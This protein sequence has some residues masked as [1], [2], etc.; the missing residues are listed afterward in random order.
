MIDFNPERRLV[1]TK[2]IIEFIY[3]S[4]SSGLVE[5]RSRRG[6]MIEKSAKYLRQMIENRM[7]KKIATN[8]W[9]FTTK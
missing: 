9:K 1:I 5:N 2:A 4:E 3:P 7:S 6:N 8:K